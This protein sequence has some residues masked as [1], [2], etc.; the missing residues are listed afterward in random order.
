MLTPILF[1]MASRETTITDFGST[2]SV[3]LPDP[4]LSRDVCLAAAP[5]ARVAP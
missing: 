2:V 1:I 5:S 3:S 4:T